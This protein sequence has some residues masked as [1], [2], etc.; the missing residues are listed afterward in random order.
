MDGF[1]GMLGLELTGGARAADKFV[2]KLRV[3][4]HAP[5]LG[6][7]DSL[8]SEPRHSSHGHLASEER[9][10]HG[11]PDGFLR[12]SVGIEDADDLIADMEQA[13]H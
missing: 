12:V 11:F 3:I 10:K 13:L 4:R 2:R 1:G 5:S 9:A 7:V 6:G 8:V